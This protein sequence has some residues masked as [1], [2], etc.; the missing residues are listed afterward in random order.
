MALSSADHD[1]LGA[2]LSLGLRGADRAGYHEQAVTDT[3]RP[4]GLTPI[5]D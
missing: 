2:R 4:S 1:V 3:R 5:R